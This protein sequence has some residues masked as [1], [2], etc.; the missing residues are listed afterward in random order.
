M[1]IV[2][3]LPFRLQQRIDPFRCCLFK[4]PL[5]HNF[6]DIYLIMFLGASISGDTSAMM[7]AFLGNVQNLI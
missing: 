3:V 5:K 1:N 2:K 7:L 6:L 4:G